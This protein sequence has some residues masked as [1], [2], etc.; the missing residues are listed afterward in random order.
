MTNVIASRLDETRRLVKVRDA[1]TVALTLLT[2]AGVFLSVE[3]ALDKLFLLDRSFRSAAL[4]AFAALGAALALLG[5][6]LAF[7]R[8]TL[9]YAAR[10]L[11]RHDPSLR[12]SLTT[13]VQMRLGDA[14]GSEEALK[15]IESKLSR[16]LQ[17]VDLGASIRRRL[18]RLLVASLAILL[19]AGAASA[20][21]AG[22]GFFVC[23]DRV[24]RPGAGIAPPT[25]TRIVEVR[26]GDRHILQATDLDIVARISG[27]APSE[28]RVYMAR[29]EGVWYT[30]AMRAEKEAWQATIPGGQESYR[31]FIAAGDTRSDIYRITVLPPPMMTGLTAMVSLPAYARPGPRQI[32]GGDVELLPRSTV[33]LTGVPNRRLASAEVVFDGGPRFPF[34][35]SGAGKAQVIFAPAASGSYQL[36]L[37]DEHGLRNP[38]PPRFRVEIRPDRPPEIDIVQPGPVV[39]ALPDLP[40]EILVDVS[41]DYGVEL[42]ELVTRRRGSEPRRSILALDVARGT[43]QKFTIDPSQLG[44]AVPDSMLYYVE[45][46]DNSPD[47]AIGRSAV[48][49]LHLRRRPLDALAAFEDLRKALD[50]LASDPVLSRKLDLEENRGDGTKSDSDLGRKERELA[51]LQAAIARQARELGKPALGDLARVREDLRNLE[52]DLAALVAATR[53][54]PSRGIEKQES[55]A[56]KL[57]AKSR[58]LRRQAEAA[59]ARLERLSKEDASRLARSAL[60]KAAAERAEAAQALLEAAAKALQRTDDDRAPDYQA[61]A[62]QAVENA[63]WMVDQILA[64]ELPEADREKA[65][66]LAKEQKRIRELTEDL[67]EKS[68]PKDQGRRKQAANAMKDAQRALEQGKTGAAQDAAEEAKEQLEPPEAKEDED[69]AAREADEE[70]VASLIEFLTAARAEQDALHGGTKEIDDLRKGGVLKEQEL[71]RLRDVS[72]RERELAGKVS[73]ARRALERE[74]AQVFRWVMDSIHDN[75]MEVGDLLEIKL[76][77]DDE[78]RAQQVEISRRI[79]EL[80]EALQTKPRGGGGGGK[81]GKPPKVNFEAELKLIRSLQAGLAAKTKMIRDRMVSARA[82]DPDDASRI[83]GLMDQQEELKLQVERLVKALRE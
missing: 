41:D 19:V 16:D 1:A 35:L 7:R 62:R 68:E 44:L 40:V 5:I 27:T 32:A 69:E 46:R 11:E 66:E 83:A 20:V 58:E 23:V 39:E 63:L 78:V 50:A 81:G 4:L 59:R 33:T 43:R 30:L 25:E 71:A 3:V 8:V 72:R 18:A 42:L 36:E 38:R 22:S 65:E 12:Q 74:F 55:L 52:R 2:F 13:C 47:H 45:A 14:S 75:M 26:P 9:L 70:R 15:L 57:E 31:Y 80:I 79:T 61:A 37:V 64:A 82:Q 29:E 51:A 53:D 48:H 6:A 60:L 67:A 54:L 24:L 21:V 17:H 10:I 56:R 34:K 77:T 73:E 28:A 76:R 49:V